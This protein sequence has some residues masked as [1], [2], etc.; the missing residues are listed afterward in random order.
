VSSS[1]KGVLPKAVLLVDGGAPKRWGLVGSPQDIG[2]VLSQP[3]VGPGIFLSFCS[4]VM[5]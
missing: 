5:Q 4:I 2:D 3:I 1:V